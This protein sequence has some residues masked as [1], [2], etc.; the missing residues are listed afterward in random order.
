[1]NINGDNI[2]DSTRFLLIKS[3]VRPELI[4][5]GI[6]RKTTGGSQNNITATKLQEIKGSKLKEKRR[7]Y[8][9]AFLVGF[10]HC[11]SCFSS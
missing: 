7:W 10:D 2:S 11:F 6:F 8:E 9:L 5:I 4:I 3:E 1:M